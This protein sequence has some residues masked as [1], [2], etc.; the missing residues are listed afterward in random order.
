MIDFDK[1]ILGRLTATD[2]LELI[3]G[4][5][6]GAIMLTLLLVFAGA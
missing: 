3:I 5:V 4:I 6:S 1:Q 2:F